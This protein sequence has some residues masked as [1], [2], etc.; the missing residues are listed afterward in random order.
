[1]ERMLNLKMNNETGEASIYLYG[2]IL[3]NRKDWKWCEDDMAPKE[4]IDALRPIDDASAV[5]IYFNSP[6]GDCWG[7]MAIANELE[8]KKCKKTAHI[9]G[10]CASIASVI[11]MY[12]DEIIMPKN[13]QL[14]I[15]KPTVSGW[16][17]A[18][19]DGL[20]KMADR[21]DATQNQI[22]DAYMRKAIKGKDE[23]EKLVNEETWF[24]GSEAADVFNVT[25]VDEVNIQNCYSP[26]FDSYKRR[27]EEIAIE[28]ERAKLN[29]LKEIY[30]K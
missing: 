24:Y 6:G 5:D 23:I 18:N 30:Q 16:L 7:G 8:R 1:M 4:I 19:A 12:C 27:P 28:H 3:G 22:V 10:V 29:L 11:A 15:H 13:A 21:M 14:M 9:D 26:L 25:V 20:R 2:E 17:N